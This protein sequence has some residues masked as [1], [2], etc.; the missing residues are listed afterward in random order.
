VQAYDE[1]NRVVLEDSRNA[2]LLVGQQAW[3]L[4]IPLVQSVDG[5]WHFDTRK[6][7]TEILSRRIGANELAAIQVC[8][9]IVDAQREFSARDSD[10]DGLKEFASRFTSTPGQ[11]DGLYWPT[12][13]DEPLSPLGPLLAAAA[14][15]GY[16]S[17]NAGSQEPY[18]GYYY[19]ILTR[20]GKDAPGGAYNYFVKGQMVAGFALLAYPA[21]YGA[22]GVMSFM[23]SQDGVVYQ[24]NLGRKTSTLAAH[25]PSFNPDTSW[26]RAPQIAK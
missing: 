14:K 21:R 6:G 3:P 19:R 1:A 9:A 12:S 10:G 8:L 17:P 23:V 13:P 20:Q 15:D 16:L 5:Q 24:K 4:P 26:Q 22:S 2:E 7:E 18:Q 11:R 25:V